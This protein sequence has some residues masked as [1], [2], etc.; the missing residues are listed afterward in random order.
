MKQAKKQISRLIGHLWQIHLKTSS[1]V[2]KTIGPIVF[3]FGMKGEGWNITT[4]DLLH[5]PDGTVGRT[6]GEFLKKSGLELLDRAESHDVFHVLFDY[7]TSIKDEFALQFFLYGN[8]KTSLASVG[9]TLGSWFMF[10]WAW[11][12]FDTSYQ[13]GKHCVDVSSL[14]L[15]SMLSKDLSEVKASLVLNGIIN[16]TKC[17]G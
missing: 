11:S 15:K 2:A 3:D 14:D 17:L 12:Y 5:F 10:P 8:G 16:K 7:S 6:L 4:A 13:R 1:A 9:T